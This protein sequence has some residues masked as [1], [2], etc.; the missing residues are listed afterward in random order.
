M[1]N[2]IGIV[3]E[4]LSSLGRGFDLTMDFRLRYRK[5]KERLIL[6]DKTDKRE[7]AVP[8][9]G[10]IKDVPIDIKCDKGD[11]TRYQSDILDFN[12]VM[13]ANFF[14]FVYVPLNL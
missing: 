7:I 3:E 2:N 11:R 14:L 1:S 5:G 12:Q 4:A 10:S 9:F 8:G 13:N 6:L